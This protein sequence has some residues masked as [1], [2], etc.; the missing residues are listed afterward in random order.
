MGKA[1][2][3]NQIDIATAIFSCMLYLPTGF[4]LTRSI[5]LEPIDS[6]MHWVNFVFSVMYAVL[7]FYIIKT[8]LLFSFDLYN[9][10]SMKSIFLA[11][12]CA[13]L[14]LIIN[15][16]MNLNVFKYL[17]VLNYSLV[18]SGQAVIKPLPV[19]LFICVFGPMGEELLFRGYVLKGLINKYGTVLAF[20]FSILLFSLWHVYITS[21]FNALTMGIIL[22][23]LYIKTRSVSCCMLTHLLY[24]IA[25]MYISYNYPNFLL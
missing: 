8:K 25:S 6:I 17:F 5:A 23:L 1:E 4:I 18:M 21:I 12:V 15:L 20:L 3:I 22:G 14:G 10:I 24:N 19:L 16:L 13:L 9:N 7:F 11:F 2:N